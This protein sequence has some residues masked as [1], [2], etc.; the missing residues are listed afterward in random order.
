M[1]ISI[2]KGIVLVIGAIAVGCASTER[3]AGLKD[4]FADPSKFENLASNTYFMPPPPGVP[5]APKSEVPVVA[6]VVA[7]T[8]VEPSPGIL[9]GSTLVFT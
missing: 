8:P 6:S 7:T 5:P 2:Q 1:R 9:D 4:P 3:Q